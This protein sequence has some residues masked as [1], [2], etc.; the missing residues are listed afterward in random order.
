[1][2]RNGDE[3]TVELGGMDEKQLNDPNLI[4]SVAEML[5]GIGGSPAAEEL[6]LA[7]TSDDDD[8]GDNEDDQVEDDQTDDDESDEPTLDAD[9]EADKDVEDGFEEVE[10]PEIPD[11]Y[12][13]SGA[14]YGWTPEKI[15]SMVDKIGLEEATT[16][17][18][19]LHQTDN[20]VTG[21]FADLGRKS[22][23]IEVQGQP[24]PDAAPDLTQ[25]QP[26]PKAESVDLQALKD[27]LGEGDPLVDVYASQAESLRAM[28]D[29]LA[30]ITGKL[31][32]TE[33]QVSQHSI[34]NQQ[35]MLTQVNDFFGDGDLKQYQ[36]FYGAMGKDDTDWTKLSPAQIANRDH[37]CTLADQIVAG[38]GVRGEPMT[39]SDA[40]ERAHMVVSEPISES[41]T[42]NKIMKAVE[43]RHKSRVVRPSRS[44]STGKPDVSTGKPANKQELISRTED[45]LAFIHKR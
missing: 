16:M 45:R 32:R 44:R 13:R 11:A 26:A 1:M 31:E 15:S 19:N 25:R 9:E 30:D 35:T 12:Y 33:R 40:M 34:D 8:T 42:R 29:Q 23:E 21:T 7:P 10:V 27:K 37:V 5:Q 38:A 22:K 41:I 14:R 4:G 6:E 24:A 3:S 39:F 28:Q 2:G 20:K 17:L 43:K 36:R 18:Q